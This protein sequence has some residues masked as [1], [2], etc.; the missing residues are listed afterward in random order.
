[1]IL[2]KLPARDTTAELEGVYGH[3]A[4]SLSAVKKWCKRFVNG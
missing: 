2:K 3:G 1:L 4:L